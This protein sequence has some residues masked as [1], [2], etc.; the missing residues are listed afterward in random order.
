MA[1]SGRWNPARAGPSTSRP[2]EPMG[3]VWLKGNDTGM[4]LVAV[5]SYARSPLGQTMLP[6]ILRALNDP[7]P[8]TR[9]FASRAVERIRGRKLEPSAYEVTAPPDVRT[10]QIE[11]LLAEV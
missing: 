7:D 2:A 10:R 5:G 4:R 3:E 11:Q 6:D 8:I 1:G 9:V